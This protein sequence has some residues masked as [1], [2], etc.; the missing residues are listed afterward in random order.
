MIF[1]ASAL[2]YYRLT[3]FNPPKVWV[4][5]EQKTKVVLPEAPPIQLHYLSRRYHQMGVNTVSADN[6]EIRIYNKEKT[7]CD[8]L[9]FRNEIG[10]D[11]CLE[12]LKDYLHSPE[13]SI[14]RILRYPDRCQVEKLTRRYVEA[15]A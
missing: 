4:A 2:A 5:V 9:R 8:C 6:A 10:V 12:A 7:L 15:M 1:L 11:I 14:D 13:A 3:T